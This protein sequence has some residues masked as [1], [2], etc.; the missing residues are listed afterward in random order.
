MHP[1]R[2]VPWPSWMRWTCLSLTLATAVTVEAGMTPAGAPRARQMLR[3]EGWHPLEAWR[4]MQEQA[5]DLEGW[6]LYDRAMK[7]YEKAREV[8]ERQK[9]EHDPATLALTAKIGLCLLHLGNPDG[10]KVLLVVQAQQ[11]ELLP[12]NHPSLLTTR[13][14]LASVAISKGELERAENELLSLVDLRAAALGPG[15]ADT[16]ASR[17]NL[18]FVLTA[19]GRHTEAEAQIR[20]VFAA[21]AHKF[22]E[23]SLQACAVR[24]RLGRCLHLQNRFDE[25]LT[26]FQDVLEV[27]TKAYGPRHPVT[28]T[29][30]RRLIAILMDQGKH[31][32]AEQGLR[33]TLHTLTET[34]GP[35]D[36]DTLACR[37]SLADSLARQG[38]LP[39]AEKEL[40]DV[41]AICYRTQ[42][43]DSLQ[44][45][46]MR[47]S[48]AYV[49]MEVRKD[50]A[51]ETML[52]TALAQRRKL[53]GPDHPETL[54]SWLTLATCKVTRG[55]YE[56]AET[57]LRKL[58]AARERIQ[59]K[60][61]TDTWTA[62]IYLAD[63]LRLMGRAR[64]A[65]PIFVASM[66]HNERFRGPLHPFTLKAANNVA[67]TLSSMGRSDEALEMIATLARLRAQVMGPAH[68]D[69]IRSRINYAAE[70]AAS[71]RERDAEREY[72]TVLQ[73]ALKVLGPKHQVTMA[74]FEG[75]TELLCYLRRPADAA[76]I[77]ASQLR[78][79]QNQGVSDDLTV[80]VKMKL[81]LA[82]LQSG[83]VNAASPL[84]QEARWI[85]S[86]GR[87]WSS[88]HWH[89]IWALCAWSEL[90]A[91]RNDEA[92]L[93]T[94]TLVAALSRT[95]PMRGPDNP[96]LMRAR[97]L[98]AVALHCCGHMPE[99]VKI[100]D[101]LEA[102]LARTCRSEQPIAQ[103]RQTLR[104][105]GKLALPPLLHAI[106]FSQMFKPDWDGK[107]AKARPM[108]F[109][110]RSKPVPSPDPEAL[111]QSEAG[112]HAAA[113]QKY[114]AS[115]AKLAAE[116]AKNASRIAEYNLC[117]ASEAAFLGQED[118]ARTLLRSVA[119][120]VK[121]MRVGQFPFAEEYVSRLGESRLAR[122]EVKPVLL[123]TRLLIEELAGTLGEDHATT[124]ELRAAQVSLL[125][126]S[127]DPSTGEAAASLVSRMETL[128]GPADAKTLAAKMLLLQ[129][130]VVQ[131]D[132]PAAHAL[133]AALEE[134]VTKVHGA[135]SPECIQVKGAL[136]EIL[137]ARGTRPMAIAELKMVLA[138]S[139]R[140]EGLHAVGTVNIRHRLAR[141]YI[142]GGQYRE[143]TELHL[144]NLTIL[145]T[146]GI[147][148]DP[149]L[150]ESG[151]DLAQAILSEGPKVKNLAV[152]KAEEAFKLSTTLHGPEHA[153]TVEAKK[154]LEQARRMPDPP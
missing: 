9:G 63:V 4:Y 39:D 37:G 121:T 25:A 105:E 128:H 109:G 96:I 54:D 41:V 44:L 46:E 106:Q 57:E 50:D 34:V 95:L 92:A 100:A 131:Q 36:K 118:Q 66:Q 146:A 136:A 74:G 91:G 10:E 32:L 59:G 42:G 64:E 111:G 23:H 130:H 103:V 1:L 67:I 49:F 88:P 94:G 47:D 6:G 62:R 108:P 133:A 152:T 14:M 127:R 135:A 82:L 150:V 11:R 51:A 147:E 153:L 101:E 149:I 113:C 43:E 139:E 85:I 81:G 40:E 55:D 116:P 31:D 60:H 80:H 87:V 29:A 99:A 102:A 151:M 61:H 28:L 21:D 77:L 71:G 154:L 27:L 79:V 145:R 13:H 142:R 120:A 33:E 140:V 97:L 19:M 98:H 141:M 30:Q 78:E 134:P 8:V 112:D 143:G 26:E 69:A 104:R 137:E 52:Q 115:L 58:V 93:L 35:E 76:R 125:L 45:Q 117:L 15:H 5:E 126:A 18:A 110:N 53:L 20:L 38:K 24:D 56:A 73:D 84:I 72:G 7:L 138:D 144:K 89:E 16:L 148:S 114:E 17:E 12:K 86:T 3:E 123:L 129:W 2:P 107:I 75:Y 70:L 124:M 122:G 90:Y 83:E 68:P 48:L 22:G 119:Q 132:F 65:L